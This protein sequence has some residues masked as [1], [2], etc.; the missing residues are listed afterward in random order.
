M[1]SNVPAYEMRAPKSLA[2]ALDLLAAEPGVWRPFAGGTDLMVLFEAGKLD[3]RRFL[4]IWRLPELR[5]ISA[6]AEFVTL[7]ALTTY[8]DVLRHDALSARVSAA[9]GGG[10]KHRRHRHAESRHAGRQH[11]ERVARRRFAARAAG[12][13]CGTGAGLGARFAAPPL[14]RVPYRL[15]A[16]ATRGPTNCWRA[17]TCGATPRAGVSTTGKWGRAERR[18]SRR[19]VS[20]ACRTEAR[21]RRGSRWPAWR[22]F[23]CAAC[24]PKRRLPGA[25]I[26]WQRWPPRSAPSTTSAPSPHIGG[27]WRRICFAI[28]SMAAERVIIS[29]RVVLPDGIRP[30]AIHIR[31][32]RVASGRASHFEPDR[33][34]ISATW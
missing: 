15:Q 18:R 31:D 26:H 29:R 8:T 4:S 20:P 34:W 7:G 1:R 5:G 16:D 21:A 14:S 24:A 11:R 23:R 27:A 32:G 28:F 10:A 17:F 25:A 12:L 6:T 13:R 9:G 2:E 3:H 22:P 30:A 33:S 19:Y